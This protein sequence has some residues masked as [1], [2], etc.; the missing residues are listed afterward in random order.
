MLVNYFQAGRD[1]PMTHSLFLVFSHL[2][3]YIQSQKLHH[4]K[5]SHRTAWQ[6]ETGNSTHHIPSK[7]IKIH[8]FPGYKLT[9][10][11]VCYI[12]QTK[13]ISP[14]KRTNKQTKKLNPQQISFHTPCN[15]WTSRHQRPVDL[16]HFFEG[17]H[18][19]HGITEVQL[20]QLR[21]LQA[22]TT[23]PQRFGGWEVGWDK[24]LEVV[25]FPRTHGVRFP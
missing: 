7:S 9:T 11:K 25:R 2:V 14:N 17:S 4:I 16:H 20:L 3:L 18:A 13:N 23:G 19:Y 22:I 15:T 6:K 8:P 12:H 1:P 5:L 10:T 21:H 24:Y